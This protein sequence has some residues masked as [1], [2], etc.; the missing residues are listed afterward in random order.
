MIFKSDIEIVDKYI[1]KHVARSGVEY[2]WDRIKKVLEQEQ[3]EK[4][5][6]IEE[7][8][9]KHSDSVNAVQKHFEKKLD[10]AREI[11]KIY[12]G[13]L[14]DSWMMPVSDRINMIE[15]IDRLKDKEDKL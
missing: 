10:I 13:Q 9:I 11:I 8:K 3:E 14:V 15:R 12:R 7:L 2:A 6:E 1:K 5:E 4:T